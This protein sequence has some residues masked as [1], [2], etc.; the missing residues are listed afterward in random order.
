M[1]GGYDLHLMRHGAP[2]AMHLMLGHTD[3]R[4][5]E[6]GA[7]ACRARADAL[8]VEAVFS[9]D[10]V[11]AA[12]PARLIAQ[13]KGLPHTADPNWR[14]LDFG[15]WDGLAPATIDRAAL[16][17]FWSDPDANPPPGGECWSALVARVRSAI[18]VLPP[19]PTL[20][21]THAGAMRAAL[22]ML[23]GFGPAQGWALDLPYGALLSL[24][25]WPGEPMAGQI[26]GLAA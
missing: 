8:T 3:I 15:D 9:S 25:V 14:E 11:R 20:I 4:P 22:A 2:E 26:I 7:A 19:R 17:R 1:T 12:D 16:G 13:D 6:G 23:C 5:T 21:V 18:M 10:L 24:R